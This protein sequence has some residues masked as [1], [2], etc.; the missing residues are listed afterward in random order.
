MS[1]PRMSPQASAVALPI[2]LCLIE[3]FCDYAVV[4]DGKAVP[5][6]EAL[7]NHVDMI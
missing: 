3:V 6:K 4:C 5:L 7:H 2:L 1:S